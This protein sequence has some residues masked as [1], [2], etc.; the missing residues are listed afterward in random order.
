MSELAKMRPFVR[1]FILSSI[2]FSAASISVVSR[3]VAASKTPSIYKG[4]RGDR[5]DDATARSLD[6]TWWQMRDE[7]TS[8]GRFIVASRAF[9]QKSDAFQPRGQLEAGD[10]VILG[11]YV[12]ADALMTATLKERTLTVGLWLST[13][14]SLIWSQSVDLHPSVLLRAHS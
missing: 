11:R 7:L 14:G 12:E 9:L 3:A 8:T 13:D 1:L 10:A 2:L 4:E 6:E 5:V